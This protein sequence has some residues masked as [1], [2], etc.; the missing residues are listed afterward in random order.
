MN[1]P[2]WCFGRKGFNFK[3]V[4][5]KCYKKVFGVN[6]C[7]RLC[8]PSKFTEM[9]CM[10]YTHACL[11]PSSAN[12]LVSLLEHL[13]V[14]VLKNFCNEELLAPLHWSLRGNFGTSFFVRKPCWESRKDKGGGWSGNENNKMSC[15]VLYCRVVRRTIGKE[16]QVRA[17]SF[18][19]GWQG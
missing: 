1:L 15:C 6:F 2:I 14:P 16:I 5:T 18:S 3:R 7:K 4:L 12:S 19:L 11:S 8:V 10:L 9:S 13:L 17:V